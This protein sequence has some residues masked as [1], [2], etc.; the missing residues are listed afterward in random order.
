MQNESIINILR[1]KKVEYKVKLLSS[2]LDN[3][4]KILDLIKTEKYIVIWKLAETD[5]MRAC[6]PE[7]GKVFASIFDSVVKNDHLVLIY[8]NNMDYTYS[9]VN[10]RNLTKFKLDNRDKVI[11]SLD[12]IIDSVIEKEVNYCTYRFSQD[13]EH[14][15][16]EF[17]EMKADGLLMRFY[18][19]KARFLSNEL[20]KI[21]D[22]FETYLNSIYEIYF[23]TKKR[24]TRDGYIIEFFSDSENT[25]LV[26]QEWSEFPIK[27]EEFS[28][29]IDK[30]FDLI[31]GAN[32]SSNRKEELARI[33]NIEARRIL[34]DIKY[35]MRRKLLD[36]DYL[37]E[38]KILEYEVDDSD[39]IESSKL[40]RDFRDSNFNLPEN[41][42]VQNLTIIN[43]LEGNIIHNE[44]DANLL[45]CIHKLN[46]NFEKRE[47]VD[48]LNEINDP[49]IAKI[50]KMVAGS[51]LKKFLRKSA[52]KIGEAS[53]QLLMSYIESKLI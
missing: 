24:N 29:S 22:L 30:S 35:E 20:A 18:I 26:N 12:M 39:E 21:I 32:I 5:M 15:V 46:N 3:W 34:T 33:L 4:Y 52:E 25:D 23:S 9:F 1:M 14:L 28:Q 38:N 47:L 11:E 27:I 13:L 36:L 40:L 37:V 45:E 49:N 2:S 31:D 17:V 7:Y 51:K 50:E 6:L 8:E 43:R 10:P 16:R 44:N 19:P 41:A 42:V 48:S 53:F